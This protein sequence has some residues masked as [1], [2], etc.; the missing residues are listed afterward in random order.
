LEKKEIQIGN[1]NGGF[2][3][4]KIEKIRLRLDTEDKTVF[5]FSVG[6]SEGYQ[7]DVFDR[8]EQAKEAFNPPPCPLTECMECGEV[9]DVPGRVEWG[10]MGCARC[11]R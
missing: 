6:Y 5:V 1:Y 7:F 11:N 3:P 8:W 2:S 9:F 10:G 4:R